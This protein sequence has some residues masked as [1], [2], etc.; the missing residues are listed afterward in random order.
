MSGILEAELPLESDHRLWSVSSGGTGRWFR[1]GVI[2]ALAV[3]ATASPVLI[4]DV[5]QQ[6]L[7]LYM[8]IICLLA[9]SLHLLM[10]VAGIFSLGQAAFF[11]FGA[12]AASLLVEKADVDGLL[13]FPL[14]G[15][16]GVALGLLMGAATLRTQNIY[17]ALATLAFGFIG[18]NIVR[19]S[20]SLGA[21]QGLLGFDLDIFGHPLLD[22]RG[23]YWIGL[24]FLFLLMVV[25]AS[26]RLSKVGR[27]LMATRESPIAAA[28]IGVDV[29]RYRLLAFALAGLFSSVAGALYTAYSS[30]VDPGVFSLELTLS[31]LTITIVG[32]LRSVPGIIVVAIVL[33]YFRNSAETFG[34]ADY[35][36]LVY[37]VVV[38]ATLR[39]LPLGLGGSLTLLLRRMRRSSTSRSRRKEEV[40]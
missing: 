33:T 15:L 30:I 11:G 22:P 35:V 36:L 4:G 16:G 27:A 1:G 20:D 8:V 40:S 17:L 2:L 25:I 23:L 19:N 38:V 6:F 39:F 37:G 10:G 32:G 18:E 34:V 9:L 12:Y 21:S 29:R 7:M 28:S 5:A 24:F 13:M 31:V 14:V 26:I 3:V